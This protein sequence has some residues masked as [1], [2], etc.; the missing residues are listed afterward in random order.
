MVQWC[1][2]QGTVYGM[3]RYPFPPYTRLHA[4]QACFRLAVE[5]YQVTQLWPKQELYG[6]TSQA[7]RAAY[8]AGANLAEGSAKR[9]PREFRRYLDISFGSLSELGFALL[10]ANR[11][12]ILDEPTWARLDT[13]QQE[14]SRLVA[15]LI[16]SLRS[17]HPTD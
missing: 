1:W 12:G 14:A 8:S 4:W 17:N 7:R 9:G 11:V 2:C 16:R 3:A 13:I 5:V 10:L 15:G 6:L